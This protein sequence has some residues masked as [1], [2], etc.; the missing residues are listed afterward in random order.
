MHNFYREKKFSYEVP[1]K[2]SLQSFDLLQNQRYQ[3]LGDYKFALDVMKMTSSKKK[4]AKPDKELQ[5]PY[6][7]LRNSKIQLETN[8]LG[9]EDPL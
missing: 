2:E 6:E 5:N 7:D 8:D 4:V 9:S 3:R 1:I